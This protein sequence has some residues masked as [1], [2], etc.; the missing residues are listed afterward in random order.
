VGDE[1][2]ITAQVIGTLSNTVDI[3]PRCIKWDFGS[4][5]LMRN[6]ARRGLL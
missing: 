3:C 1:V 4:T 5:A 2:S 6:L